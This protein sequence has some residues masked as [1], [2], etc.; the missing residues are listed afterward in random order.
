MITFT[1]ILATLW[2]GLEF[3]RD[4][5]NLALMLLSRTDNVL[6]VVLTMLSTAVLAL[7]LLLSPQIVTHVSLSIVLLIRIIDEY[8]R[9]RVPEYLETVKEFR[10]RDTD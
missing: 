2:F 1:F 3:I 6:S 4:L 8:P 9:S 5:I 10:K 7:V